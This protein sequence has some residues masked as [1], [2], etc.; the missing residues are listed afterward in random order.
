MVKLSPLPLSSLLLEPPCPPARSRRRSASPSPCV[1]PPPSPALGPG[2]HQPGHGD[3]HRHP[4][5]RPHCARIHL[6]RTCSPPRTS[7]RPAWSTGA[8]QRAAG[9]AARRSTLPRQSNSGG[10]DHAPHAAR[11]VAGPGAGA[12]QMRRHHTCAGQHRQQDRVRTTPSTPT[13]F[14]QRCVIKRISSVMV[15]ARCTLGCAGVINVILDNGGDGGEIES[16]TAP[17]TPT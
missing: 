12:G 8:G 9:A 11:L 13:R 4:C 10:A 7:A 15:P 16:A 2:R 17:T 14:R 5:R 3:R 1:F 6:P